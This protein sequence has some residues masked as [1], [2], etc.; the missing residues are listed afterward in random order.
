MSHN[1]HASARKVLID[2]GPVLL[3]Y[4]DGIARLTLN[5]PDS[6]NG[7][8]LGFMKAL[9]EAAMTCHSYP[10]VRVVLLRGAG[11]NFCAGG[12]VREFAAQGDGIGDYM[13]AVTAYLQAAVGVLIRLNAIVVAEVQGF[14][15]GG[16]GLGLVCASDIVIAGSSAKFLAG[17]TRVAMVPDGGASVI[18]PQLVGFRRAMDIL[19]S[20]RI[21]GAQEAVDIGLITKMVPDETLEA[22]AFTLAQ[23]IAK[24]APQAHAHMKRLLWNGLNVELA[25]PEEART[26]AQLAKT[27]DAHEGLRAV[28]EKR[29]PKFTG[30]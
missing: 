23:T 9:Y 28:I 5:R 29:A 16:G 25:L 12:D 15:A 18:L 4:M 1:E 22:E 24:G 21:I 14:A 19:V 30:R 10:D 7:M 11:K 6:S 8:N 27:E 2:N 13:R 17:A 3:D 26:Q 20:N